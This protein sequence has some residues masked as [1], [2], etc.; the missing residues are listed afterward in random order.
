M[1]VF[2]NILFVF[3]PTKLT[4]Y[5]SKLKTSKIS[6][7]SYSFVQDL[8]QLGLFCFCEAHS[9]NTVPDLVPNKEQHG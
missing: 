9:L 1:G 8:K 3:D 4:T 7:D 2:S 5:S 6:P